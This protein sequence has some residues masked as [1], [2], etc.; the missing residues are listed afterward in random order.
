[1]LYP[2]VI[3]YK[4]LQ[5]NEK[6]KGI[7]LIVCQCFIIST[8]SIDIVFDA[9]QL[10]W[11]YSGEFGFLSLIVY[12][13]YKLSDN[14]D[15]TIARKHYRDEI[16]TERDKLKA[17]MDGLS[18]EGIGIDIISCDYEIPLQNSVLKERF[19]TPSGKTCHS[20][21]INNTFSWET[22]PVQEAITSKK[23]V[24]TELTGRDGR[25]YHIYCA[26]LASPVGTINKAIEVIIDITERK[27]SEIK[28]RLSEKRFTQIAKNME[29]IFFL[30][31][32]STHSI[33]YI[34]P[35]C[36]PILGIHP[37]KFLSKQQDFFDLIHPDDRTGMIFLDN[38]LRYTETHNE[39][40]RII[41]PD[42]KIRWLR[43][44]AFPIFDN[45][46][47]PCRSAGVISDITDFKIAQE[48]SNIQQQ[49]L[50]QADKLASI[51][52]MVSGV[53]HEIN[54][55]NNLIMMNGGVIK[56]FWEEIKP[57]LLNNNSISCGI[58]EIAGI[59]VELTCKEF[60][61]MLDGI[62]SGSNRIQTIVQDLKNF[63]R[64]EPDYKS[65]DVSIEKVIQ[66]S[67]SL[68]SNLIKKST[69]HFKI[70]NGKNIPLLHGNRQKLEQV[71]I[72]MLT[73][74]CQAMTSKDD[75]IILS[76]SYNEEKEEISIII[77][78]TG[79]GISE[80]NLKKIMDPFFTTKRE[81][82]GT[83]LGLSV[84]YGIIKDHEGNINV[85][86]QKGKGTK[87]TIILPTGER[88]ESMR[89]HSVSQI[90][91]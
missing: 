83:G 86:S 66:T 71:I 45:H 81:D 9:F 50:I 56:T 35:M 74:A 19:C 10:Q 41:R 57:F 79:A 25:I 58:K 88:E 29:E 24:D 15:N 14:L 16:K 20:K 7:C 34:S 77:E 90:I 75:S 1:M 32:K 76:S 40:F 63:T 43:L 18:K 22:C 42:R 80:N 46:Q 87:F 8:V 27:E 69:N 70:I 21:Y 54:N 84:S 37:D 33:L 82:G 85:E 47:N 11:F 2:L 23:T 55:P 64:D 49:Q 53:A 62:L 91:T 78:D 72:N 5:K 51:G 30:M 38:E 44:K 59:P 65:N 3:A 73:N 26:P 4:L 60:E 67:Y 31:E 6:P 13:S 48:Q 52:L 17:I 39:E 68:V 61:R 89:Q 36:E 12:M 28:H